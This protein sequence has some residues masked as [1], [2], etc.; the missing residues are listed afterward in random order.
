MKDIIKSFFE[1]SQERIKNPLIGTFI[2]SWIAI[3]WRPIIILLF[4]KEKVENRIDYIVANYSTFQTYFL[5]PFVIAL[6]YVIILPYFMW[7]VDELIRKSTIGRKNNLLKQ[8]IYDYEGKQ[9]IA[10]AESKLEDLKASYRDKADF[11]NQ[12]EQLRNQLD[13]RDEHLKSQAFELDNL[14]KENNDLSTLISNSSDNKKDNENSIYEKQYQDFSE[15]D[16]FDFFKEI[17]IRIRNRGEFPHGINEIIK[18][19]FLVQ[20]IVEEVRGEN[21]LYYKFT[22]KGLLFWKNYVNN[23][24]VIKNIKPS[25]DIDDNLPF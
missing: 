8:T 24:R 20:N 1:A 10:I 9:Q 14:H 11:N 4:S 2:I 18:E 16:L 17:G 25:D 6:I 23:I 12:I 3:N 5:I 21:E 19:K 7:A 22:N 15:S 13:E